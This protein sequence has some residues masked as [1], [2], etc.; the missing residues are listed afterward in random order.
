[1]TAQSAP[2]PGLAPPAGLTDDQAA[3]RLAECGPNELGAQRRIALRSRIGAQ[4][5][6]PMIL[7]LLAAVVLTLATRDYA[8][9]VV[10]ALVIVA[11]TAVGVAQEVRADN[12]VAALSA[13][14]APTARVLRGG[15]EREVASA[16]VVPGDA[17]LLGEGD[18]VA[19]DAALAESSA[20]LVD[21]SALTGESVPVDKDVR[22]DDPDAARLRAGTV[23]VRGRAVAT[24]TATGPHSALGRIA[25]LLHPHLEPTPLQRRLAGLG[26]VLALVAVGLCLVVFVL[27]LV[28]GQSPQAMAVVAISLAV[29]AVPESLPAVVTL[30]LALGARRMAARHALVRRLAA[31]ETLGSVTML[32]TDKTGTLTE[33]R[34]VVE[35]VWTTRGTAALTG[36][37]YGPAGEVLVAGGPPDPAALRAV[38]DLLTAAALCNDA[39]LRPPGNGST[40]G[41]DG[42][43][44]TDS[45]TALGDPTEAALLAA[46]VKAGRDR[47]ELLPARPRIGEVPFDSLRKRMTTLHRAP[48]GQVEVCLKGAPEAVLD[49]VTLDES[50]DLLERARKEAAALAAEGF[51]VLAVATALRADLPAR[52]EDAETGLRL[53]GLVAISDPPK[54]AAEATVTACRLAGITPVLITG[55][56]PATARAIATRVGI[57]G[58][59][60]GVSG[61]T[62]SDEVVTGRQLAAGEV[63][64]LTRVRVFARTTPQQKLDI[65]QA[66]RVGGAV[67]AMTG[68][69][70]NDGPA[71]RQA[72]IGVAMG[73]RGT[74]VARQAADLVLADDELSTVVTAVEEGRRVYDN[75]RRFLLYALAGGVAE[76]LVMLLGPL[77]GLAL[78]LRA[79]QILWINLLTHGLTGVAMGAEPVSRHA[80]RRPPRPPGQHVLGGGLW[81]RILRLGT[82]ATCTSLAAGLW[83]RHTGQPW[84]TTLF[85]ALLAAQL[86][87]VLGLRERLFTRENPFLPWAVL[88]A[89]GLAV[90]ALYVPFLRAVL[91][92]SPPSWPGLAAALA[93]GLAGFG[94]ARAESRSTRTVGSPDGSHPVTGARPMTGE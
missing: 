23:V 49:G 47:D 53:L 69:G 84:Q 13:M 27:G 88:A 79:G 94:T 34:M 75:I 15:T 35:R 73:R 7:I 11:N 12:A 85:L 91:E 63:L 28:R 87:V 55:D 4:L 83:V 46:A 62:A 41:A 14:T 40:K 60:N 38:Q 18:I 44:G 93:A 51:R 36:S 64:D 16:V 50:P 74:E 39:S 86:G 42:A 29:A 2:A 58:P 61:D 78:P 17:L 52:Y 5:R 89:V 82:V 67:T 48:S 22:A 32:A 3:G 6:D 30:G 8:D 54:E 31:V 71:L 76:I 24:V 70:V 10:I 77:F 65:V 43:E 21:E 26:R 9:A 45:W 33:G 20:L 1:M 66:W 19:A 59:G 37:G 80:M 90:A 81:Q 25:A 92:T 56:H 68:D 57:L 72:D